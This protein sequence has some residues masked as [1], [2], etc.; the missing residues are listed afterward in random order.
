MRRE[1]KSNS[2]QQRDLGTGYLGYNKDANCGH[3][4]DKLDVCIERRGTAVGT[5][6]Y[7]RGAGP[8]M[9]E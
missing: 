7:I 1:E 4:G 6:P 8:E 3:D 9:E 2:F 5:G